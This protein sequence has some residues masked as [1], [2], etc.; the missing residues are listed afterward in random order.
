M[1]RPLR[2]LFVTDAFPPRSYGSGWSTYHLAR[3]LRAHGHQVRI[4]LAH[5]A[6]TLGETT[7]DDFRV[8]RAQEGIRRYNPSTLML[9]G[10]G[11]G[12]VIQELIHDWQPDLIHAQHVNA[13]HVLSH[14]HGTPPVVITI[15]D[16]WPICFYGTALSGSPCPSCLTGTRTVCN[17]RRGAEN[18]RRPAQMAK[19]TLMRATLHQRQRILHAASAVIGCSGAIADEVRP[20]VPPGRLHVVPHA[21]DLDAVQ[22]A[23]DEANLPLP[24]RFLL[25]VG[26]LSWH[27]G[28]D[29]LP[30]IM[31]RLSPDAP[32]LLVLGDGEEEGLLRAA[33]PTGER[34]RLLGVVPNAT[35]HALMK[36]ATAL[37]FPARWPE[38]LTRTLLEAL[39][40]GCPVVATATGGT[41][42][43]VADGET[44]FLVQPD[45]VEAMATGLRQ[46]IVDESLRARMFTAARERAA[47][48]F[49]LENVTTRT[50]EVYTDAITRAN[51]PDS[52]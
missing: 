31:A 20:F 35:V 24:P 13:A 27:K 22:N 18:A 41:P 9:S 37:I 30:A 21:V 7:Y 52:H 14:V 8:W 48:H 34:I 3:G 47:S 17:V 50:V 25:Y 43:I 5:P 36:R 38:P 42:E 15:R 10:L 45:D 32:P 26:K 6:R 19:A 11:A 46:I 33:D 29:V 1:E 16:H 49:S 4:V 28:A 51:M 23:R 2:I 12:T 44:G 39:A 40:A